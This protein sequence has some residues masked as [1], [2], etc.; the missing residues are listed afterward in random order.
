MN[1]TIFRASKLSAIAAGL[2]LGLASITCTAEAVVIE[3]DIPGFRAIEK[4]SNYIVQAAS[5][6]AAAEAVEAVGG[7]VTRTIGTMQAVG[8][9]LLPAQ[10]ELLKRRTEVR[11]VFEDTAVKTS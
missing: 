9:E 5:V 1:A 8:A 2:V 3:M 7:E 11:R 6:E 10:V 4:A